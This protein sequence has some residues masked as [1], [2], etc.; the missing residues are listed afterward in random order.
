MAKKKHGIATVCPGE[1]SGSVLLE[2]LPKKFFV[3]P[4]TKKSR[5]PQALPLPVVNIL[6]AVSGVSG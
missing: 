6:Y 2:F 3:S 4:L 1:K 5:S